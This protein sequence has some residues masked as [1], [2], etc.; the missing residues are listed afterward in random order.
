ME[1]EEAAEKLFEG[2]PVWVELGEPTKSLAPK[3]M[4]GEQFVRAT[5]TAV[6]D[7]SYEVKGEGGGVAKAPKAMVCQADQTGVQRNNLLLMIILLAM[8]AL[9]IWMRNRFQRRW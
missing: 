4:E 2:M 8:N 9:A 7:D 1:K 3:G 5:L 6:N